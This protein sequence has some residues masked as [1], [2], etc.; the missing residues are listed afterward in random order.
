MIPVVKDLLPVLQELPQ[1][2]R[3][4][5]ELKGISYDEFLACPVLNLTHLGILSFNGYSWE[6]H[7]EVLTHL[8]KL[9]HISLG[10]EFRVQCDVVSKLLLLCPFLKL[11]MMELDYLYYRS[12]LDVLQEVDNIRLVLLE[13]Q[14]DITVILDWE[15]GADGG[16]DAWYCSGLVVFARASECSFGFSV[17]ELSVLNEGL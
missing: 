15:N 6:G 13:T 5:G 17:S 12:T 2:T 4:S 9:I 1:L 11:L 10:W 14:C 8:P 7:W 16:V 3:L